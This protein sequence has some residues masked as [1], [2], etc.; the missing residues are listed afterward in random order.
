MTDKLP[1]AIK[2]EKHSC[3]GYVLQC[4]AE[5]PAAQQRGGVQERCSYG[6]RGHE[7]VGMVVTV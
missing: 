3:P 5:A 7:L 1:T 2:T 6:T 4:H